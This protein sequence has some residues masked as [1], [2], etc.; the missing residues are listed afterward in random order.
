MVSMPQKKNIIILLQDITNWSIYES[1]YETSKQGSVFNTKVVLSHEKQAGINDDFRLQDGAIEFLRNEGVDFILAYNEKTKSWL[2]LK[3]LKPDF[4]FLNT[5]YDLEQRHELYH[6][7]YLNTFTTTCYIPYSITLGGLHRLQFELP[8]Y[9]EVGFIFCETE[10][11]KD[12]YFKYCTISKEQIEGKVFVTGHPK[13]DL[14]NKSIKSRNKIKNKFF[15]SNDSKTIR[16]IWSPHWTF[17][18]KLQSSK[19]LRDRIT[20]LASSIKREL[21][22]WVF[23][24]KNQLIKMLRKI[25]ETKVI[26]FSDFD[27]TYKHF[28]ELVHKNK[29]IEIMLKPHPLMWKN[30]VHLDILS[31][32]E[33]DEFKSAW[34]SNENASI[35]EGGGYFEA[36]M[37]SDALINSSISFSAEYLPTKKPILHIRGGNMIF[38]EF[39]METI[40]AAS[41]ATSLSDIDRFIR[42]I[43]LKDEKLPERL[44]IINEF[45]SKTN[46]SKKILDILALKSSQLEKNAGG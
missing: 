13:F 44:R 1:L 19:A 30:L 9:R 46:V 17:D 34:L 15:K 10:L 31:Q 40:K 23:S 2:D 32:N 4:V 6:T 42:N 16:I 3:E 11:H 21:R 41:I 27:K 36:F 33:I 25:K 14:Y 12:L 18:S 38:N 39:G 37:E 24:T 43:K 28:L 5:P 20:V 45:F 35:Y 29:N 8:F 22:T 26:S 7:K